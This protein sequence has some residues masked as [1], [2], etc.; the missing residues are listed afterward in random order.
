VDNIRDC[1]AQAAGAERLLIHVQKYLAVLA[2]EPP[3]FAA[4]LVALYVWLV[5][6][7]DGCCHSS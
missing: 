4:W 6:T 5:A 3:V 1:G 7:G 2:P